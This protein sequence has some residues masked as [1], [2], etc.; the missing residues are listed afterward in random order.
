MGA[1]TLVGN[2]LRPVTAD[3]KFVV[4]DFDFIPT[5]GIPSYP[6]EILTAVMEPDHQF[7]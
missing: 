7:G 4:T 5:Y 2:S 3:I 1:S 6:E